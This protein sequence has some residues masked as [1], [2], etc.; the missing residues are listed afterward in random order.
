MWRVEVEE[1]R[2][3]EVAVV[4]WLVAS[5]GEM[6]V[7]E[8]SFR[9]VVVGSVGLWYLENMPAILPPEGPVMAECASFPASTKSCSMNVTPFQFRYMPLISPSKRFLSS[10]SGVHELMYK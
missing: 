3:A 5:L 8:F 4:V 10:V 6:E 7:V 1:G 9:S 2:F